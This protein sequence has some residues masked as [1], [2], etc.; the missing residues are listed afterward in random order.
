MTDDQATR[1]AKWCAFLKRWVLRVLSFHLIFAV[2]YIFVLVPGA[3]IVV[4]FLPPLIFIMLEVWL[5]SMPDILT[6]YPF[7]GIPTAV[8]ITGT[9][10]IFWGLRWWRLNWHGAMAIAM[11]CGV[12]LFG[13]TGNLIVEP[14]KIEEAK[15]LGA[16]CI[17]GGSFFSHVP[18]WQGWDMHHSYAYGSAFVDGQTYLWS[19]TEIAYAA[20]F[21]HDGPFDGCRPLPE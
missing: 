15:R 18:L 5:L 19:Y 17:S 10:A 9:G 11:I 21:A 4:I 14:I 12:F 13:H 20:P 16:S 8:S 7:A 2:V 6:Q 3:L 1:G